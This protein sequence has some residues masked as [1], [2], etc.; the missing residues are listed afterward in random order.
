MRNLMISM[1]VGLFFLTGCAGNMNT[2]GGA[3]LGGIAGGIAGT[4]IGKGTGR[5]AAIIGGTLA[6]AALGGYVGSYLDRMDQMDRRNLNSTLET[7]PTGQTNQWN[8]P[9]TNTTYAVTPTN[10][11]Q[12]QETNRY[13]REY[14]TEVIIEGNVERAYGTACRLGNGTWEIVN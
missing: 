13:C 6:G 14:S 7:R 3:A 5:T 4:Q 1:I 10:T 9:D 11:Y 8:N 2:A 12:Q